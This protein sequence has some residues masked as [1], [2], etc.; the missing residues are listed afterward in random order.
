MLR[1]ECRYCK[2]VLSLAETEDHLC[3]EA[4]RAI[5]GI[6]LL[7]LDTLHIIGLGGAFLLMKDANG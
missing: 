4:E 3:D 1:W 7:G 2:S 5:P 6:G